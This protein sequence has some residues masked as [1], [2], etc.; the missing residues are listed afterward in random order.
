MKLLRTLL[1]ASVL[2]LP[3]LPCSAFLVV[4]AGEVF[5]ANN[6]DYW[7]PDTRVWFEPAVDG[8]RGVMYL[9]YGNGFPQ[10]GM[11][12]AGLAF[13][14]FATKAKP[15]LEQKGKGRFEGNPV[16]AVMES[17][18]TVDEVVAFLEKV[19]LR[20]L[21][22]NAM[23]MFADAG[24]DSVI[25][26][27]DRFIRKSGDYQLITNFYQSEQKDDSGQ[28]PRFDAANR[29]LK[30]RKATTVESCAK[31]LAAAAQTK[32]KVATLYS[33]VFDLKKRTVTLWLFHDYGTPV[34]LNL[35]AEL[36]KGKRN[37]KLPELFPRN[38]DFEAF[39][40]SQK[41]S[42]EKRIAKRRGPALS[43]AAMKQFEGNYEVEFKGKQHSLVMRRDKAMLVATCETLFTNED[44]SIELHCASKNEFFAITE[45]GELTLK[46]KRGKSDT[47]VGFAFSV[48]GA[49]FEGVRVKAAQLGQK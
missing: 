30:A 15:L 26:E 18:A 36:A 8:K 5:F 47:V 38:A 3:A 6:E 17:C 19:D 35:D 49:K 20:P 14:G 45:V 42:V 13:D 48:G 23:L 1:A 22:T 27:G 46:F 2:S 33:N 9:G 37:L 39:I 40:D 16:N 24:G 11:N 28:C 10:G 43:A 41:L 34:V 21:M 32:G 31:A 7:T 25:I 44:S 4:G 12:D 29:V